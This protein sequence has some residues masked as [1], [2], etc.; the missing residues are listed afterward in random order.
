MFPQLR[1]H[2][3][4]L[5]RKKKKRA[6]LGTNNCWRRERGKIYACSQPDDLV[7]VEQKNKAYW[8]AFDTRA[9]K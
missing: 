1:T 2:E 4:K 7:M 9:Q 8:S 5:D 3:K 6:R